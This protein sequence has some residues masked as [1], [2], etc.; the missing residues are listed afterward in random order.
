[1]LRRGEHGH[2][3]RRIVADELGRRIAYLAVN[4]DFS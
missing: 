2:E 1:M 3:R 4:L